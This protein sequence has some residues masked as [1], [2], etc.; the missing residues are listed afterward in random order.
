MRTY[1]FWGTETPC[2]LHMNCFWFKHNLLAISACT[3]THPRQTLSR[4]S[5]PNLRSSCDNNW[6]H[7]LCRNFHKRLS[8]AK[9]NEIELIS[10]FRELWMSPVHVTLLLAVGVW[11][12]TALLSAGTWQWEIWDSRKWVLTPPP[13]LKVEWICWVTSVCMLLLPKNRW[14]VLTLDSC[15]HIPLRWHRWVVMLQA[16]WWKG[17]GSLASY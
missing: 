17:C 1:L 6:C 12:V 3:H 13:E 8:K 16:P 10:F 15:S 14:K 2:Q 4:H 9:L 11:Y 7:L 5:F